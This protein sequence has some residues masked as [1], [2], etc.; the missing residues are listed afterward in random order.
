[1]DF[2]WA[3]RARRW[4]SQ[5][6]ASKGN[7]IEAIVPE[8][9]LYLSPKVSSL[10]CVR[11]SFSQNTKWILAG[12]F[13]FGVIAVI[14]WPSRPERIL[15]MAA[16]HEQRGQEGEV[17][18]QRMRD[19]LI[20]CGPSAIAPT[21]DAI[22]RHS[23][24]TRRYAYLPQALRGLGEPAHHALLGVIDSEQDSYARAYLISALQV[25]FGD[26]SRFELWFTNSS[27]SSSSSIAVARFAGE[28]RRR[29]P[30]APDLRSDSGINPEFFR[31]WSTN[32]QAR[33]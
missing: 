15:A 8:A 2:F 21:I 12:L 30:E 22:R 11:M 23:A 4:T 25:A 5:G 16:L 14:S 10:R 26:F 1:M 3:T 18:G 31:W 27:S 17:N 6:R 7:R 32:R 20:A 24:W 33:P 19:K 29:F 9:P 28:V 13:A